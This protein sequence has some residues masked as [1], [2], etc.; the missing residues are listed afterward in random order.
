VGAHASKT[1]AFAEVPVTG[2]QS[3]W[4][5]ARLSMNAARFY[6]TAAVVVVNKVTTL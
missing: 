2:I 5:N 6:A 1:L 3:V 4:H